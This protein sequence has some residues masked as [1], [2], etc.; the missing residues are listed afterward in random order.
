M[1]SPMLSLDISGLTVRYGHLVAVRDVDLR[2]EEGA[3]AVLLG[4]NGAGKT[5]TLNAVCGAVRPAVG[6]IR[7][8]GK[9]ITG[10]PAHRVAR[11]GLVQVPEGRRIIS[12]LTVEENLLL[13]AFHIRS[14]RRRRELKRQVYEMFPVLRQKSNVAG[15]LLSGG[16]QQMLA[17]GRAMMSDPKAML[18]DEPSMGLAP[19]MVTHVMDAVRAI[20]ARGISILMVEQNAAPVFELASS[21]YVLE[22]G[23]VILAGT[24]E[25][26]QRDPL[27][28][29]AFLGLE[30]DHHQ[31]TTPNSSMPTPTTAVGEQ[32][33]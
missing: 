2:L 33:C 19:V 3:I 13:G 6:V 28:L 25:D 8:R 23:G 18:L 4:S 22:S 14:P 17:F 1:G 26:V 12:P 24:A 15:G 20:A 27:V 32:T 31:G 21:A 5:S 16:Q 30:S 11:A 10:W 9:D 29:R 7:F